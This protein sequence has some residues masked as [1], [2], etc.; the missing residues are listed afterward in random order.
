MPAP[1][2]HLARKALW[3]SDGTEAGTELWTLPIG[4]I[5]ARVGTCHA[6]SAVTITDLV[7][8]VNIALGKASLSECEAGDGADQSA[9][10]CGVASGRSRKKTATSS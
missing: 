1:P 8:L 2:A 3:K 10:G 4:A 6:A 5:T 9:I 7:E